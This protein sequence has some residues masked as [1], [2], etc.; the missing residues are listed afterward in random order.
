ME[1][2]ESKKTDKCLGALIGSVAGDVLGW[3]N[4]QNSKNIS[5]EYPKDKEMFQKWVR[6]DGGRFWTH[7]EVISPGEYSDD[8]QL[9]LATARSLMYGTGWSKYLSK[10][11]LPAWISYER[12]GGGATKRSVESWKRGSCPWNME[13]EKKAD[14]IRY[15]DAGGNGVAMRIL[16]HVF[17]NEYTV[18]EIIFQVV[19]NGI[20]THGHPRALIGASIYTDALVYLMNNEKTLGYGELVDYLLKRKEV[21]GVFPNA[22]NLDNWRNVADTV[23]NINYIELWN[24]VVE[25][26]MILLVMVKEA[27]DQGALDIGNEV[28]D[29]LGCF[30][31]KTNGSGTITAVA[32]IYLASKYASQ[33]RQGLIEAAYLR[34]ADTDTLASM[35]GGLLGMLHG[36]TFLSISWIDI[37]DYDYL[38]KLIYQKPMTEEQTKSAIL[39]YTNTEIKSMLKQMKLGEY[40]TA[41]PFGKLVLKEKIIN[42]TNVKDIVVNT[43]KLVS[44]EGQSIFIKTYE[45]IPQD[46]NFPIQ[47]KGVKPT[48]QQLAKQLQIKDESA[49]EENKIN[50]TLNST[51]MRGLVNILPDNLVSAQCFLFI[52]D[53]MSELERSGT[54]KIDQFSLNY[55]KK[56]WSKFGI[57]FKRI[58]RVIDVII[59]Y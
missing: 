15:F 2:H 47:E 24:T 59:N 26:V 18:E 43:L 6:R 40:L 12:G 46:K 9:I 44:E 31:K 23:M 14:V 39:D 54:G 30:N 29:R 36:S 49:Q 58:E 25:E 50:P 37:Q 35:V 48:N 56:K 16:P 10:V 57:D 33:P 53:V 45:K 41:Q 13:K 3:P 22:K 38:K 20:L 51:K 7:E 19:M 4:E 52:S 34:N 28:L 1:G 5:K 21:W 17:N 8:T 55:L 11:E 27:L 32:A 42:K